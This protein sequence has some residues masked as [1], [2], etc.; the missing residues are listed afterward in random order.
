[1]RAF[2][3]DYRDSHWQEVPTPSTGWEIPVN[4]H[5][6]RETADLRAGSAIDAGCGDGAEAAWLGARLS[7][8]AS[9]CAPC[10]AAHTAI[11]QR[12]DAYRN[13]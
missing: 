8:A 10:D 3:K 9:S 7:C 11:D 13:S 5:L 6:L 1:M 12:S 2:D 4:P